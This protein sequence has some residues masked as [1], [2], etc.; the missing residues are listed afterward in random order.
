MLMGME[1]GILG[2]EPAV[3]IDFHNTIS[4]NGQIHTNQMVASI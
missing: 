1:D 4:K 3:L 2:L